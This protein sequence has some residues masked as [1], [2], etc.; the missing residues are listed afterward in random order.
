MI[1]IKSNEKYE[2]RFWAIECPNCEEQIELDSKYQ[3][4]VIVC[5]Y[6]NEEIELED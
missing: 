4:G 2:V 3:C 1:K 6:C 5:P